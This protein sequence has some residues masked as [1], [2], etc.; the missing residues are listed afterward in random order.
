MLLLNLEL[1]LH[2]LLEYVKDC[3]QAFDQ[4]FEETLHPISAKGTK[5]RNARIGLN[6]KFEFEIWELSSPDLAANEVTFNHRNYVARPKQATSI[7][8]FHAYE[9]RLYQ[10]LTLAKLLAQYVDYQFKNNYQLTE[11]TGISLDDEAFKAFLVELCEFDGNIEGGFS[12]L[13]NGVKQSKR[14]TPSI[15][16]SNCSVSVGHKQLNESPSKL[17][18]VPA[19]KAPPPVDVRLPTKQEISACILSIFRGKVAEANLDFTTHLSWKI[20]LDKLHKARTPTELAPFIASIESID[21]MVSEN[22]PDVQTAVHMLSVEIDNQKDKLENEQRSYSS[23]RVQVHHS[24][25]DAVQN[26]VHTTI[27]LMAREAELNKDISEESLQQFWALIDRIRNE[28]ELEEIVS[29]VIKA[30]YQ[31]QLH[32]NQSTLMV[33][34]ECLQMCQKKRLAI[35]EEAPIDATITVPEI[36][37]VEERDHPSTYTQPILYYIKELVGATTEK[38]KAQCQIQLDY[39]FKCYI[40]EVKLAAT[41]SRTLALRGEMSVFFRHKCVDKAGI[42]CIEKNRTLVLKM[43]NEKMNQQID[44]TKKQLRKVTMDLAYARLKCQCLTKSN[45][46]E[47]MR[48]TGILASQTDA[49]NA[50]AVFDWFMNAATRH[51]IPILPQQVI[52]CLDISA[53]DLDFH[54]K[55]KEEFQQKLMTQE[56][57]ESVQLSS[58][59]VRETTQSEADVLSVSTLQPQKELHCVDR[60][61]TISTVPV[62]NSTHQLF[63]PILPEQLPAPMLLSDRDEVTRTYTPPQPIA[64]TITEMSK[65][66]YQARMAKLATFPSM[67]VKVI[68]KDSCLDEVLAEAR[69]NHGDFSIGLPVRCISDQ[70][71]GYFRQVDRRK[72]S[73]VFKHYLG[74]EEFYRPVTYLFE[75]V[76][77]S[78]YRDDEVVIVLRP[79]LINPELFFKA[80]AFTCRLTS[81]T[82]KAG[83]EKAGLARIYSQFMSNKGWSRNGGDTKPPNLLHNIGSLGRKMAEYQEWPSS[84]DNP[85][86]SS[87]HL[88]WDKKNKRLSLTQGTELKPVQFSRGVIRHNEVVCEPIT[89]KMIYGTAHYLSINCFSSDGGIYHFLGTRLN[90]CFTLMNLLPKSDVRTYLPFMIYDARRGALLEVDNPLKMLTPTLQA[91]LLSMQSVESTVRGWGESLKAKCSKFQFSWNTLQNMLMY[92]PLTYQLKCLEAQHENA[93][94]SKSELISLIWSKAFSPCITILQPNNVAETVQQLI[95]CVY[96]CPVNDNELQRCLT[97]RATPVELVKRTSPAVACS[98]ALSSQWMCQLLETVGVSFSQQEIILLIYVTVLKNSTLT[99]KQ[100]GF[101][102]DRLF[103]SFDIGLLGLMKIAI[104]D[105]E[106]VYGNNQR[107]ELYRGILTFSTNLLTSL[108]N[109]SFEI[110]DDWCQQEV[111]LSIPILSDLLS[112]QQASERLAHAMNSITDITLLNGLMKAK[113]KRMKVLSPYEKYNLRAELRAND[114]KMN[115]F[116]ASRKLKLDL[117]ANVW[118]G[119]CEQ[120]SDLCKRELCLAAEIPLPNTLALRDIPLPAMTLLDMLSM[121]MKEQRQ[122]FAEITGFIG[123]HYL[124]L[125]VDYTRREFSNQVKKSKNLKQMIEEQKRKRIP[126][127][128]LQRYCSPTQ[129]LTREVQASPLQWQ[130]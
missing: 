87:G 43:C 63:A 1:N 4:H 72:A 118:K 75:S 30:R 77:I 33:S 23:G 98:A 94:V 69:K 65:R 66:C 28:V 106:D 112:E 119:I 74:T 62:P 93:H 45:A 21:S 40:E 126:I 58:A 76:P 115:Q 9:K 38:T 51:F 105:A 59:V 37:V 71:L 120:V 129:R 114:D 31:N 52:E 20:V 49:F 54:F 81:T 2:H 101:L 117:H 108:N 91:P 42:E 102:I 8:D 36:G 25:K 104:R 32:T 70:E 56:L 68:I 92:S 124:P 116:L 18:E 90:Q 48:Y 123:N 26:Q 67:A 83:R 96:Y 41:T 73:F 34:Y 35:S 122:A 61:L 85:V 19:I 99:D 14:L 111:I 79:N 53:A 46:D 29:H 113:D 13:F 22:S 11:V 55:N 12:A 127:D 128:M 24:E 88:E 60:P 103:S 121:N 89:S 27:G 78:L 17:S 3:S 7:T 39:F 80:N 86:T 100:L 64:P 110:T 5:K 107:V 50:E 125:P 97:E 109:A 47:L 95:Q 130:R 57:S 10:Q 6:E 84:L 44:E 15:V 16:Y 82:T